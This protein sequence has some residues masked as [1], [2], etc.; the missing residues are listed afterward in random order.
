MFKISAISNNIEI[1]VHQNLSYYYYC[2]P[3][4]LLSS[5]LFINVA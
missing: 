5:L 3:F 1:L 4:L 2:L